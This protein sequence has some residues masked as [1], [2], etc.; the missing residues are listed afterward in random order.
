MAVAEKTVRGTKHRRRSEAV[1]S[2]SVLG[3]T[4]GVS[5]AIHGSEQTGFASMYCPPTFVNSELER[6]FISFCQLASHEVVSDEQIPRVRAKLLE[7]LKYLVE[8]DEFV[9]G[10]GAES[11]C[12]DSLLVPLSGEMDTGVW[13]DSESFFATMCS[14]RLLTPKE[15]FSAFKRMHYFRWLAYG[16]LKKPRC[17]Q[18]DIARAQGLLRAARWHR[19]LL[20]QSNM[21]LIVSIVKRLP[22]LSDMHEEL[23][24]DGIIALLRAI[25][26]F[27]PDRGYRF[28]T[29]ATP[30]IRREC[31]TQMHE[32]AEDSKSLVSGNVLAAAI[33]SP[34]DD[35]NVSDRT[36]WISWRKKLGNLMKLLTRRE[37]L[38]I[39]SRYCLGSHREVKTLQRLAD[40]LKISKERVR[41]LEHS[42]LE[43]LRAAA[44]KISDKC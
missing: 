17:D 7:E 43:K 12:G 16:I 24:S 42:A 30:V 44:E 10:R 5:I 15:E 14:T 26:R 27:N 13:A 38:I 28:C 35:E 1:K 31:F 11:I 33:S 4:E 37:Q 36:H 9:L 23:V 6:S 32:R 19:D 25:D 3:S 39:R 22:V 34:M 40:A 2:K 18:W 41:Q 29:Y 20:V 21:R 8:L